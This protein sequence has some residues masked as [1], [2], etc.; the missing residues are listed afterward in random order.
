M[1]F[2]IRFRRFIAK[3]FGSVVELFYIFK[4]K[5][6]NFKEPPIIILTP[7]KVGS[8]SVYSTLKAEC[9]N[10]VYHLHNLSKVG[11]EKSIVNHVE[12]NRKSKPLHLIISKILRNKLAHY[13]GKLYIITILREPI[14]REI[15]AFFQ[16]TEL[17][18]KELE[19]RKLE[20]DSEKALDMLSIQLETNICDNLKE[21][22][23]LEILQ[24]FGIDVFEQTFN[25]NK[26]Y[27]LY[28][29]GQTELLV[30]KME[31]LDTVFPKAISAFLDIE[32]PI[33][34]KSTNIGDQ[35]YYA[36]TYQDI[37]GNI[38]LQ[39]QQV[40]QIVNSKY[41]QHFYALDQSKIIDKWTKV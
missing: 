28:Q 13:K 33:K 3:Y 19:N 10:H 39:P 29:N 11:I 37:K 41:F 35:K 15:S 34:I 24:N 26:K 1:N 40:H 12:S 27:A 32:K 17:H 2:K 30:I 5:S 25:V 31:D 9:S 8:S 38:K 14:S 21:W 16:N 20:I 7:G 18:K 36:S 6:T 4:L 22:F 23:D